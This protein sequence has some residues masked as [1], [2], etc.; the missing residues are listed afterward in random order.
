[1]PTDYAKAL[2]DLAE[3]CSEVTESKG[4]NIFDTFEQTFLKVGLIGTEVSEAFDVHRNE[5]DDTDEDLISR[6]T[7]MQEQDFTDELADIVI[8]TLDLAGYL[9]L[10]LG[11]AIVNK[12]EKNKGRPAR[13]GRRY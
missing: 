12:I 9:E 7:E 3:E 1:M 2:N 5:Y 10:D 4:F 6:M 13:H 8:R 11:T